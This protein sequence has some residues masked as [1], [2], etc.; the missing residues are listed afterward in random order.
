MSVNLEEKPNAITRNITTLI[1][2]RSILGTL[3]NNQPFK[4]F[5]E[6][7]KLDENCGYF[8]KIH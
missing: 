8:L 2:P 6:P 5:S 3:R 4:Y 1:F 7:R